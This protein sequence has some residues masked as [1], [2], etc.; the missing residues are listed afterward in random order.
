MTVQSVVHNHS[1][2]VSSLDHFL[3]NNVNLPLCLENVS[4][5]FK[6]GFTFQESTILS[7]LKAFPLAL[8]Y[9]IYQT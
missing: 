3:K 2:N 7:E 1:E 8:V 9:L 4:V 6:L 5:F